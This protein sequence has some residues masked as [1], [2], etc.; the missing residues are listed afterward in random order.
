MLS[1]KYAGAA[2][3]LHKCSSEKWK[4][5]MKFAFFVEDKVIVTEVKDYV[6]KL[7]RVPLNAVKISKIGYKWFQNTVEVI[8][9]SCKF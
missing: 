4:W 2:L 1:A 6:M 3:W 9:D 8:I 5:I 7:L